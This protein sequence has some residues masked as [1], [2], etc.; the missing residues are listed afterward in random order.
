MVPN[1]KR[2]GDRES[3]LRRV[4]PGNF[5]EPWPCLCTSLPLQARVTLASLT[6]RRVLWDNGQVSR[7]ALSSM[8]HPITAQPLHLP[9]LIPS[10]KHYLWILKMTHSGGCAAAPGPP[11]VVADH[12]G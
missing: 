8:T 4:G 3:R 6:P 9:Q 11:L 5:S 1:S 10:M 12:F 2:Y 7:E